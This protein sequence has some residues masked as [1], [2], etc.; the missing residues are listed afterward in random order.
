MILDNET[1]LVFISAQSKRIAPAC[2][3]RLKDALDGFCPLIE[4][5]KTRY[6]WCRDYMPVQVS[7]SK[8]IQYRY[9]PDYMRTPYYRKLITDPT[10]QLEV[11]GF[12]TVKTD[13]VLDAGNVVM[14][15]ECII[16]VDKIFREN[17]GYKPN[18]LI[19]KLEKLF[20]TEIMLLP[21]DSNEPFGHADGI[22]RYASGNNVILTSYPDKTHTDKIRKIL[23]QK[24]DIIEL[25][26]DATNMHQNLTWAYINFLQTNRGIAVPQLGIE[27]DEQAMEQF[28]KIFTP[29]GS[30]LFPINIRPFVNKGGGLNCLTWNICM[31][32]INDKYAMAMKRQKL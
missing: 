5:E 12:E 3:R 31:P 11:Y 2:Y 22:V 27:E 8:M 32:Y 19:N 16:M 7:R 6:G 1:E 14:T 28:R 13:I 24:F 30:R 18:D 15:P 25:K 21:F 29:V 4:L 17:P 20:E 23:S 10:E 26:Y 9:Y